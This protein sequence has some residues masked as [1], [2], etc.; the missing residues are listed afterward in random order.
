[1]RRTM[2][3]E[4]AT[5]GPRSSGS[6]RGVALRVSPL[7]FIPKSFARASRP[8]NAGPLLRARWAFL[9]HRKLHGALDREAMHEGLE[10]LWMLARRSAA[11]GRALPHGPGYFDLMSSTQAMSC[12]FLQSIL[13]SIVSSGLPR[14]ARTRRSSKARA[15]ESRPSRVNS[16]ARSKARELGIGGAGLT[17][18]GDDQKCGRRQIAGHGERRGKNGWRRKH[19]RR[20]DGRGLVVEC[21]RRLRIARSE[22]DDDRSARGNRK[23]DEC[24]NR[25]HRPEAAGGWFRIRRCVVSSPVEIHQGSFAC[26][27]HRGNVKTGRG[28][29]NA[30]AHRASSSTL[31]PS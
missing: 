28:A 26:T 16:F 20:G 3:A 1:M 22:M 23:K 25:H 17:A 24:G 21:L 11:A 31:R 13:R 14:P 9:T 30:M 4:T 7:K 10:A 19:T 27:S 12:C 8:G 6:E 15:S 2:N 29:L 18:T 5:I